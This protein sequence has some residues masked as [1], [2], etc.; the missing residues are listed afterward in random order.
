M[1][2][3]PFDFDLT[4]DTNESTP[5]PNQSSLQVDLNE[6]DWYA[7]L[8]LSPM[9]MDPDRPAL[10]TPEIPSG[11]LATI[12][13]RGTRGTGVDAKPDPRDHY[14]F[15]RGY[16]Y[17]AI[18]DRC[19]RIVN[20]FLWGIVQ[21]INSH[22]TM[23]KRRRRNEQRRLPVAYSHLDENQDRITDATLDEAIAFA[24]SNPRQTRN[25]NL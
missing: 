1:S 15:K 14:D 23:P 25:E 24:K 11:G 6:D 10:P 8:F 17:N 18:H 7:S 20:T 2:D 9:S 4:K 21:Y 3:D 16:F 12:S 22:V 5:N 13:K 19:G